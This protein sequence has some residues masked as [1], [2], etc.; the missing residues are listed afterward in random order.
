MA[1]EAVRA[2]AVLAGQEDRVSDDR[3]IV[4]AVVAWDDPHAWRVY[5]VREGDENLDLA[6]PMDTVI[7][8][9]G[10][11]ECR[12]YKAV[13]C[14]NPKDF[15]NQ[16]HERLLGFETEAPARRAAKVVKK[17]LARIAKGE[18]EP[19]TFAIQVALLFARSKR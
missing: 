9:G 4:D 17:E 18:P 6:Q 3:K 10:A 14:A 11:V 7:A 13:F 5:L 8:D 1:I 19:D 16:E 12:L 2:G 15:R